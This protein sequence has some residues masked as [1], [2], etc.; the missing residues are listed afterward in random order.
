MGAYCGSHSE[1]QSQYCDASISPPRCLTNPTSPA[2]GTLGA[3]CGSHSECQ[4]NYCD[5]SVNPFKCT[6]QGW[7]GDP[8]TS[9]D[10][11]SPPLVCDI[12]T[13]KCAN[14][15]SANGEGCALADDCQSN[16]CD[17]STN[18]HICGDP[19]KAAIGATCQYSHECATSYCNP[20][21]LM[22]QWACTSSTGAH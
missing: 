2:A 11:C 15:K 21:V 16:H 5:T 14:T 10:M 9:I 13:S 18:Y 20:E 4:T 22:C 7:Y 6:K 8:C 3:S 12:S 1:C 17:K 19:P